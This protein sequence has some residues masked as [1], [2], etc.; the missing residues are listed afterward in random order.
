MEVMGTAGQGS[1]LPCHLGLDH[2][3]NPA[4]LDADRPVTLS[5]QNVRAVPGRILSA[6]V[7]AVPVVA[8]V[9]AWHRKERKRR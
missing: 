9:S 1:Q 4:H 5:E 3:A 2:P 7:V 6:V 8:V